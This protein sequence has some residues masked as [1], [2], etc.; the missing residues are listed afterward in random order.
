VR[1]KTSSFAR[2]GWRCASVSG[3]QAKEHE[4]D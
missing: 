4:N 1:R 3:C 2:R